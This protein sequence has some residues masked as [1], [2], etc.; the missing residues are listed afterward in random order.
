MPSFQWT[1]R[2]AAL[3]SHSGVIESRSR[4]GVAQALASRG[5]VPIRIEPAEAAPE[6][7]SVT[8]SRWLRKDLIC[9]MELLMFSRHMHTLLRSG[10]PIL[11]AL[12]A[13]LE[14]TTHA[15]MKRL[16][17]DLRTG[18]DSGLTLSQ[19]LL[20]HP[21]VFDRFYVAMVRVGETSGRL[22]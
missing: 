15:G 21:K 13:L 1:G 19:A 17:T 22:T 3:A 6:E 12:Q 14:S 11:R 2:D 5:I 16:L 7:A 4:S 8:F 9:S 20:K 18:L 10:V